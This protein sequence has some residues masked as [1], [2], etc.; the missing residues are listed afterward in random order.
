MIKICSSLLF[1]AIL[2]GSLHA[3][4]LIK[5]TN[6]V[7][8]INRKLLSGYDALAL[9]GKIV[10]VEKG[11]QYK[12]PAGTV[13]IDGSGKYL[14]PGLH[15]A[16]VHFFQSGSLYARPDVIDL[17]KNRPYAAEIKY[18]HNNMED[19]LRRYLATGITSVTDVGSTYNFLNRRESFANKFY[20]PEIRMTGA[21]LTTYVPAAYKDLGNDAP[22]I[23]MKTEEGVRQS[24]RELKAGKADFI[25]IWYIVLDK[26]KEAGA[27]KNL[28]LVKAVIDEARK[29]NMRVAVHATEMITAQLAVEAGA[30]FLVHNIENERVTP[31]FTAL[32][33]KKKTVLC[34]TMVVGNN[35]MKSLGRT[36]HFTHDELLL[37]NPMTA[38][39]LFE[40]PFPDT[41][42]GKAYMKNVTSSKAVSRQAYTDSLLAI[43]LKSLH[44]AGVLIATGTDAG[45]IGTQH[46]GS[47]FSELQA[48]QDAGLGLWD[49]MVSST[50]NGAKATGKQDITGSVSAGK[51]ADMVLLDANPLDSLENWRKIN[52]IIRRGLVIRPD[53]L[54]QNSPELLAQQQLNG[55]NAHDIDAFL[56]PYAEDAEIYDLSGKIIMKGKAEMRKNYERILKIPGLYCRLVNRIVQDNIVIDHEE[57]T[58]NSMKKPKYGIAIYVTAK[59]KI[60]KVYFPE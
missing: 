9:D 7:D 24:V 17:R 15:D 13:V 2:T 16:H 35:Y 34:P 25:K 42:L 22:F 44:D 14:I 3:Q 23:E 37:T 27:K 33:K 6:V 45:N 47:Y 48:M 12:L 31:A 39:S 28:P 60:T 30:D 59:G 57:L 50:I 52:S 29:N 38:A 41:T 55:Y 36:Y 54:I 43:N 40:F 58:A 32:L 20:S 18:S 19:F 10:S 46:A 53:T 26:D 51:L 49:L 8:V 21:L 11:K 56:A 1:F 4:V 5:N